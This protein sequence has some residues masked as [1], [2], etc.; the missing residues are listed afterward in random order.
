MTMNLTSSIGKKAASSQIFFDMYISAQQKRIIE[1]FSVADHFLPQ[2]KLA[3]SVRIH[4]IK[5]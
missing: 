5:R 4:A 2:L 1:R 3:E